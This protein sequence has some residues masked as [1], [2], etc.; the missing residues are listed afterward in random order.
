M[1]RPLLKYIDDVFTVSLPH[2]R[3]KSD[4]P[5]EVVNDAPSFAICSDEKTVCYSYINKSA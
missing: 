2:L 5:I 1:N 3:Q 4:D